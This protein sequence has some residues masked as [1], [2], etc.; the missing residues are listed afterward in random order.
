VVEQ[1]IVRGPGVL[2]IESDDLPALRDDEFVDAVE[3][4]ECLPALDLLAGGGADLVRIDGMRLE[5]LPS[6]GAARSARAVV[7]PLEC[8]AHGR[9]GRGKGRTRGVVK[10]PSPP[11]G[12]SSRCGSLR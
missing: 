11:V 3:E 7:P 10:T 12:F 9:V 2:Q 5:K 1:F 6:L 8:L 4:V